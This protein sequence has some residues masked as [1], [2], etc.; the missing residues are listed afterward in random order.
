MDLRGSETDGIDERQV[1]MPIFCCN[2]EA[3][4]SPPSSA[5]VKE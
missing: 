1:T 4:H 2:V 5:E 3:D